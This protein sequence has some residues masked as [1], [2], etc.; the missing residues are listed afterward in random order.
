MQH[1][2]R[3]QDTNHLYLA[4]A[5]NGAV[6]KV[7]TEQEQHFL[8]F[9]DDAR[10]LDQGESFIWTSERSGWRH[11]YRVSRDGETIINLTPGDFDITEIQALDEKNGWLYYIASPKD[12]AQ[13]YLFRS[14]L[15]AS[16]VN[17]QITPASF[18]G[19]NS[20]QMSDDG[21]WAI[22]SFF[23]LHYANR[24]TFSGKLKVTNNNIH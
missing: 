19:T 18:A 5:S 21:Q 24:K 23:K 15:D 7:I 17:Q 4:N 22:H 20:Y 14:K 11:L 2:N 13:R 1:V 3:K 10:W 6:T 12:V 16:I 8:D 9:Y